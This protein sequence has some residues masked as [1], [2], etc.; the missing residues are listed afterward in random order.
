MFYQRIFKLEIFHIFKVF[1]KFYELNFLTLVVLN[2][3]LY[4]LENTVDLA[5]LASDEAI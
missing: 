2:L 4:F 1:C 5:Q 3:D